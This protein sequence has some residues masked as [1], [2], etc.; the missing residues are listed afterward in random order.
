MTVT[1][2]ALARMVRALDDYNAMIDAM[3]S[4]A[5][6]NSVTILVTPAGR[7]ALVKT[8]DGHQ[9]LPIEAE[10]TATG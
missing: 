3:A 7:S 2:E 5:A 4:E 6:E 9:L 1:P 10:V 8:S